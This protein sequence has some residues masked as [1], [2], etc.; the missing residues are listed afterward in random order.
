[1]LIHNCREHATSRY[2]HASHVSVLNQIRSREEFLAV[3]RANAEGTATE[4]LAK[5]YVWG[6]SETEPNTFHFHEK[7]DGKA[8]FEAHTQAPHF[9][10]WEKFAGSDPFTTDPEVVFFN[11]RD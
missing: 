2:E 5:E 11:L 7:Y 3:V 10:N 4:P 9:A 1:M 8:G 6:E